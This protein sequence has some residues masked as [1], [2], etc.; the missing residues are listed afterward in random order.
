MDKAREA[1]LRNLEVM[2]VFEEPQH[3]QYN[4]AFPLPPA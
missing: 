4:L 2:L 3:T 1:E